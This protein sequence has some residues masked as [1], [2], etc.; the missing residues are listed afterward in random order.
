ME[1]PDQ[2]GHGRGGRASRRGSDERREASGDCRLCRRGRRRSRVQAI[3]APRSRGRAGGHAHRP[4]PERQVLHL[5]L[6]PRRAGRQAREAGRAAT[7][8]HRPRGRRGSVPVTRAGADAAPPR[9]RPPDPRRERLPGGRARL[10]VRHA[11]VGR[12]QLARPRRAGNEL[13]P[14]PARPVGRVQR[15][16]VHA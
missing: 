15:P 2:A 9:G 5:P 7:A 11:G 13:D 4:Y 12:H 3:L 1:E 14:V 8:G 6:R 10:P 16:R